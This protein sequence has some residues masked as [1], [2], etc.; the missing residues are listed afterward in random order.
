MTF[1]LLKI[2][3]K[4]IVIQD[5][6]LKYQT[7]NICKLPNLK[8][9]SLSLRFGKDSKESAPI[10]FEVLTFR[11]SC[12]TQSNL[13]SLSLNIRKGD[14]VGIK[15]KLRKQS[16][17]DFII[18]FLYEILPCIK[19]FDGLKINRNKIHWQIKEIFVLDQTSQIYEYLKDLKNFTIVI[20]GENLN[21]NFFIGGRFPITNI[22]K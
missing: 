5:W 12:I 3:Y 17:Y 8:E 7:K 18:L 21:K 15:L 22:Y 1:N 9:V 20:E 13:N 10:L 6:I 4:N 16:I 19:D 2:H 14:P 11:R